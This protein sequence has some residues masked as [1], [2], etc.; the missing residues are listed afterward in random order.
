M[1]VK[2]CI[3]IR[4]PRALVW[5]VTEKVEDWSKWTPTIEKIHRNSSEKLSVGSEAW[6]KQPGLPE[7]KWTV[8]EFIEPELFTWKAKVRG[9]NMIATHKL[10]E[11][12]NGM[13]NTLIL[14]VPGF[15]SFILWPLIVGKLA[16][17]LEQENLGLKVYCEEH[18]YS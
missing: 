14:E 5:S 2:N 16:K 17:S 4:A 13:Q 11:I 9:M 8:I 12:E 15:L 3:T 7:L 1:R 18:C 10:A 6:I